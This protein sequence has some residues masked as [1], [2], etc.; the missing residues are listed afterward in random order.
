MHYSHVFQGRGCWG[1]L[2]WLLTI[3]CFVQYSHSD[4]AF[5]SRLFVFLHHFLHVKN[6]CHL[7]CNC[8]AY[9]KN[10]KIKNIKVS[11]S[12]VYFEKCFTFSLVCCVYVQMTSFSS[13][14]VI[15][16]PLLDIL[17]V[18][19]AKSWIFSVI[20]SQFTHIIQM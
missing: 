1:F 16:C 6:H 7:R 3:V 2:D 18:F 14:Q 12:D 8:N 17:H 13:L 9:L 5:K 11:K 4:S 10:N 20:I 15:D 19:L